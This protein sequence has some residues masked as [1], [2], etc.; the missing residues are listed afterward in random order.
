[1]KHITW[2]LVVLTLALGCGRDK[3]AWARKIDKLVQRAEACAD[4]AC[5]RQVESEIGA[6]IG[7]DEGRDL[8]TGEP[9]LLFSSAERIRNR[10]AE[11]AAGGKEATLAKS[12]PLTALEVFET[13]LRACTLAY[14]DLRSPVRAEVVATLAKVG[15]ALPPDRVP[16]ASAPGG[17]F[18]MDAFGAAFIA[19]MDGK[20]PVADALYARIAADLCIVNYRYDAT[21]AQTPEVY[22]TTVAHLERAMDTLGHKAL[23][24]D[25]VAAV[26]AAAPETE[27]FALTKKSVLAIR[28]A[29]TK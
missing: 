23:V 8:D 12:S 5:A 9:E 3:K 28:A 11:L 10:V 25:V 2:L 29:L 20:V 21:K 17:L 1:M 24:A 14:S 7:S 27:V 6:I 15:A 13:T 22:G 26:R 4:V 16:K 18:W 19:A